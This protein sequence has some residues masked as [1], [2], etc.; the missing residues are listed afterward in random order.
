MNNNVDNFR[1][2]HP[3]IN[4]ILVSALGGGIIYA[5]GRIISKI[6]NVSPLFA[7]VGCVAAAANVAFNLIGKYMEDIHKV[8]KFTVTLFTT[9]A[10]AVVSACAILALVILGLLD[11]IA[12]S[13]LV[14]ISAVY[15]LTGLIKYNKEVKQV[16]ALPAEQI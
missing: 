4:G 6:T 14:A 9:I 16:T 10:H 12:I 1:Y 3:V 5:I 13:L 8:P 7:V 11:P 2:N 15:L